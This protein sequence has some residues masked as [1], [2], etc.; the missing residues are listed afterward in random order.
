MGAPEPVAILFPGCGVLVHNRATP[1]ALAMARMPHGVPYTV[2]TSAQ[3]GELREWDA[4][5]YR[6]A[7]NRAEA[8]S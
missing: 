4:E 3:E 5:I 7:L 8:T 1:V 2:L 6:Q